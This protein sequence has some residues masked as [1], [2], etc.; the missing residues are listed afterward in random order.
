MGQ[1][2]REVFRKLQATLG[3]AQRRAG[4]GL[5]GGPRNFFGGAF[6]LLLLGGG[7]V[8]FN[9]A[10]FNGNDTL[11]QNLANFVADGSQWMVAIEPS[12]IQG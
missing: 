11:L 6:G 4:G 5:P 1:D 2:P 9:N 3:S 7:V 12:N 10:L 8:V